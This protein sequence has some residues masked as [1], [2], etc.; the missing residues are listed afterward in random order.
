ML[1]MREAEAGSLDTPERRAA[2]EARLAQVIGSIGDES[3]RRYYRHEFGQRL[4]RL[5]ASL[6]AVSIWE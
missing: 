2:F 5:F 6:T 3:V 4:R 1:W